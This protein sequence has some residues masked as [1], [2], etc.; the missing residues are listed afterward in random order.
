MKN[1]LLIGGNGYIGSFLHHSLN[2]KYNIKIVDINWFNDNSEVLDFKNLNVE[3][4]K[5]FDV[6]ILLASDLVI[7]PII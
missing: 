1:I 4:I 3:Y 6:V 7:V 2:D 5:D